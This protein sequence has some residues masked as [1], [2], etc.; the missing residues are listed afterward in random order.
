MHKKATSNAGAAMKSSRP[1]IVP[2]VSARV[3]SGACVPSG[4]IDDETAMP[5]RY[6][7]SREVAG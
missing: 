2:V 6:P 3:K 1:M 7:R 4:T 5:E